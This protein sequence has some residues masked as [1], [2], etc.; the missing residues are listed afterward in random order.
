MS[1]EKKAKKEERS[2]GY[3]CGYMGEGDVNGL[4]KGR[5]GARK[6]ETTMLRRKQ[7]VF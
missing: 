7:S 4:T 3:S 5:E 6:T 2:L 1:M